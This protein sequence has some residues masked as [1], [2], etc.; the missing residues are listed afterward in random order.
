VTANPDI[1]VYNSIP[2]GKN[3][4]LVIACDGIWD[5]KSNLAITEDLKRY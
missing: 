2:Q 1:K 5:C 4:F 3:D